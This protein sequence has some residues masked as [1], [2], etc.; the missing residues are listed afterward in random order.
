[1]G[2]E[3]NDFLT[4]GTVLDLGNRFNFVMDVFYYDENNESINKTLLDF[5]SDKGI[6]K[7]ENF[8]EK[9][10]FYRKQGVF[11]IFK[12]PLDKIERVGFT[13]TITFTGKID[14]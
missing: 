9:M 14:L 11:F 3:P 5:I 1:V 4:I 8:A 6:N 12:Q 13:N 7:N 10:N 2:I